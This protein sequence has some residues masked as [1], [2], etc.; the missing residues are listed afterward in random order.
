MTS[1]AQR[2]AGKGRGSG[3]NDGPG[4]AT[5]SKTSCNPLIARRL[6]EI[7]FVSFFLFA[8]RASCQSPWSPP[9][10]QRACQASSL[11]DGRLAS[12]RAR[13]ETGPCDILRPARGRKRP[14]VWTKRRP[15]PALRLQ[16]IDCRAVA[17]NWVRFV[18]FI[19]SSSVMPEPVVSPFRIASVSSVLVGRWTIGLDSGPEG[20]WLLCHPSPSEG[21]EKTAGLGHTAAQAALRAG[22]GGAKRCRRREDSRRGRLRACATKQKASG[23]GDPGAARCGERRPAIPSILSWAGATDLLIPAEYSVVFG[24]SKCLARAGAA[25]CAPTLYFANINRMSG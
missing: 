18:F 7:G 5:D 9:S 22:T 20:D 24:H 14:Q 13:K 8:R 17:R 1:F 11:G 21:P 23:L 2:G 19:R 10:E 12:T 15:S 6:R 4:C 25:R 3:P 16:P